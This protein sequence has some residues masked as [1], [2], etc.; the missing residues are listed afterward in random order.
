MKRAS[1][2]KPRAPPKKAKY[3]NGI[4]GYLRGRF[5]VGRKKFAID[6]PCILPFVQWAL[7]HCVCPFRQ[8][9]MITECTLLLSIVVVKNGSLFVL[10]TAYGVTRN[11]L[12][13]DWRLR[14]R[15]SFA[16]NLATGISAEV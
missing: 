3:A 13:A 2:A 12:M 5:S 11:A 14:L 4:Q 15:I 9:I 16:L 7:F 10:Y 1:A 6:E 8:F